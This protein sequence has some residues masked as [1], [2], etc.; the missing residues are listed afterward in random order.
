MTHNKSFNLNTTPSQKNLDI[1]TLN[2]NT[3]KHLNII[4][5]PPET[6]CHRKIECSDVKFQIQTKDKLQTSCHN[7]THTYLKH[8]TL[9]P[10]ID[11]RPVSSELY[12]LSLQCHAWLRQELTELERACTM[13]SSTSK[14]V[15]PVMIA[16]KMKEPSSHK[17]TRMIFT[18]K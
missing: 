8:T 18:R 3:L 14:F 2:P 1:N 5:S 10:K 7:D 4:T 6:N 13:P 17:I 9:K 15:S 12:T 16:P 11:V